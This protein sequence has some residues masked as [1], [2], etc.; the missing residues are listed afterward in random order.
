MVVCLVFGGWWQPAAALPRATLQPAMRGHMHIIISSRRLPGDM[1]VCE[2]AFI[3]NQYRSPA[4]GIY[5]PS[6]SRL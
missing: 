5:L 3:Y 2:S 4:G 1:C 6:Q